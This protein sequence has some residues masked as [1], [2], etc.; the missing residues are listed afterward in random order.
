MT[1]EADQEEQLFIST[2]EV[3]LEAANVLVSTNG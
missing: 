2:R 3:L 1:K